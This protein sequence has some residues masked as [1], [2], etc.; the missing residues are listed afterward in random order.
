M[1]HVTSSAN[2]SVSLLAYRT[3]AT[4]LLAAVSG[5]RPGRDFHWPARAARAIR[6]GS[7]P[8]LMQRTWNQTPAIDREETSQDTN[9]IS[10]LKSEVEW[11]QWIKVTKS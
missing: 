8:P 3:S 2:V 5:L 4:R 7:P 9:L 1:Y 11:S 6:V 10:S